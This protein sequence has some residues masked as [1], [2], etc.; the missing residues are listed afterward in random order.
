MT[1]FPASSVFFLRLFFFVTLSSA[2]WNLKNNSDDE[3]TFLLALHLWN[4][5]FLF[6]CLLFRDRQRFSDTRDE[7]TKQVICISHTWRGRLSRNNILT[8]SRQRAS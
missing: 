7:R 6:E 4:F 2:E 5:R 8:V 3:I 1:E